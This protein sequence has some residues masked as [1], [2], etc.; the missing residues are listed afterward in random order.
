[1]NRACAFVIIVV[2]LNYPLHV[3]RNTGQ[4]R[5]YRC[6]AYPNK[7]QLRVENCDEITIKDKYCK[8]LCTSFT[9]PTVVDENPSETDEKLMGDLPLMETLKSICT[10]CR[11]TE[12]VTKHFTVNCKERNTGGL[13]DF[14]PFLNR[15]TRYKKTI[16]EKLVKKCSCKQK[17][18]KVIV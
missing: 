9:F 15:W 3:A 14:S 7:R 10:I 16:E 17:H 11:P 13:R 1:M 8:G 12:F 5:N 4:L 6:G 2:V 18:C